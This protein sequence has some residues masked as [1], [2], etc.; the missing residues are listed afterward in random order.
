MVA[1]GIVPVL[2]VSLYKNGDAPTRKKLLM[3]FILK[4]AL[5]LLYPPK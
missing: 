2:N 1:Q 5:F 3:I 4:R